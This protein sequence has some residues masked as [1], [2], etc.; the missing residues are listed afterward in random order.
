MS[1][2]RI[3]I[4]YQDL[5][6]LRNIDIWNSLSSYMLDSK[7]IFKNPYVSIFFNSDLKFVF[8]NKNWEGKM[9]HKWYFAKSNQ[10]IPNQTS[11]R[12]FVQ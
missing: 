1:W 10:I 8:F 7:V 2:K 5:R 9:P 11:L 12:E 6:L 4:S 3:Q